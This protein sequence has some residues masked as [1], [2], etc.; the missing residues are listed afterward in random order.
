MTRRHRIAARLLT[1]GLAAAAVCLVL[2][3]V[4]SLIG[5]GTGGRI[6]RLVAGLL[7]LAEGLMLTLDGSRPWAPPGRRL[8]KAHL[9]ERLYGI[10]GTAKAT[11]LSG[12]LLAGT[13]RL[14]LGQALFILGLVLVGFGALELTRVP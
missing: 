6:V 5:G 14:V 10:D 7:M 11:T 13:I 2:A 8:V 9:L 1:W 12:R 3:N 4:D